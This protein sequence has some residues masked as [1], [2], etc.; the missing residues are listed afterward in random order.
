MM[1]IDEID[2]KESRYQNVLYKDRD[3]EMILTESSITFRY[4]Q[5]IDGDGNTENT[6]PDIRIEWKDVIKH[7]VSP[8]KYPKSLLKI[9]VHTMVSGT[10]TSTSSNNKS[11][12]PLTF[13][14]ENR[15]AL[16]RIRKDITN[17]L[18]DL[19]RDRT[20]VGGDFLINGT[21]IIIDRLYGF[22]RIP[23]H[24]YYKSQYTNS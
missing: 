18:H 17:R 23:E 8:A 9:L 20:T 22:I 16:Q 10:S 7:Q 1:E 19:Q 14:L 2:A 4:Q 21:V 11:N 12:S 6:A 13:Q 5:M 24:L 15:E 3:G